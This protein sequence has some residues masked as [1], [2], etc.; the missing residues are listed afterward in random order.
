MDIQGKVWGVTT[1]L[2][3]KNNVEIHRIEGKK[4]GFS[5]WH[6]HNAKYNRFWVESGSIKVSIQKDYGSG[7]LEDETILFAGHQTTVAPGDFHKFEVLEDCVVYEIYWVELD[8]GDIDRL[9][10]GGIKDR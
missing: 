9:T 5:S 2:F 1:P 4:G 6:K 7:T 10:V 3:C 8:P